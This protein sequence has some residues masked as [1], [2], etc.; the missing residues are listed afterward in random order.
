MK[1]L[2]IVTFLFSL[3]LAPIN[4]QPIKSKA[5]E[6]QPAKPKLA[7]VIDDFGE[8]RRGVE[9]ML[10]LPIKLTVA[11]IPGCEFSESDA[12]SAHQKGHEVILHQ[13]MENQTPM[14]ASY[15]GPI[16][17]KNN[18]TADEAKSTIN[19]AIDQIPNCKG[20]NIHM[21][22]GVSKNPKL[23]T[24]IMEEVKKRDIYFL[25]SRT[26]EGSVCEECAKTTG[27]KFYGRD[28]FLEPPGQ[29]NYQTAV[30]ELLRAAQI[31]K[32][33]GRAVTIGHVGPVGDNLT[34]KAI[35]DTIPQ[36]LEMGIEIVPLS[37][38]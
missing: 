34:A 37:E 12:I 26:I 18:D 20:V 36:I 9:E 3:F 33:N 32:N 14:P 5:A 10:S 17:I 30:N 38:L 21:G 28:V 27:V 29:P 13:P 31:A 15:Y 19:Q 35:S 24:A 16:L 11:V 1:K 2:L 22:T 4:S 23:I 8:D 7:I 6:S 25:D